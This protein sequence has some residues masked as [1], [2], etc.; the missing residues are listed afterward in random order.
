MRAWYPVLLGERPWPMIKA[1]PPMNLNWEQRAQHLRQQDQQ[2]LAGAADQLAVTVG[3]QWG[4]EAA[5]WTL[6]GPSLLPVRWVAADASLADDWDVLV[7]LAGW[8]S[9]P[10]PGTWATGP[11]ELAGSGNHLV[12]MLAQ[13][14]TGRLVVLGE[15]GAGKTMLIV[16]LVLDLLA[17]RA[18]GAPVPV[19]ASLASWNPLERDLHGWLAD[20]LAIDY[21][22][23]A[24]EP[25]MGRPDWIAA[26]LSAGLILPILDGLDELPEEV[27][28]P[29]INQINDSMRP[30]EQLI[31]TCRTGPYR[32][33]VR[34]PDAAEIT[35]RAAAVIQL[36]PLDAADVS[37]YLR[38]DF[39]G[40]GAS[41]RW[42]PV[43][44]TLGTQ[45]PAGRALVTPLMVGLARTI[46]NPRPSEGTAELRDPAE[47][48]RL[49]HRAEVEAHLFDA[50]IPAAYRSRP[51]G[52]WDARQAETWL[53]IL[54]SRCPRG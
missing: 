45:A 21:P 43:L 49:Q 6:N 41:A 5:M 47:L 7:Q 13:V 11:D 23:V 30:G 31:V 15:P 33:A 42:D 14:P 2:D 16:R 4:A 37:R 8:P 52:R 48:C 51:P 27:R 29:A 25:G 54:N 9:L 34:P 1:G 44:A 24:A 26:L 40:V 39:G 12:K 19:L 3:S 20:Q 38:E 28:R 35:L 50:F 18:S 17:S 22:A 46:Y 53:Q 10:P 36:C 32:E